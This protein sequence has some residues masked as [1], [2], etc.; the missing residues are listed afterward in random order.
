MAIGVVCG[1]LLLTGAG[2]L[3]VLGFSGTSLN[4]VAW[5]GGPGREP[6]P[7]QT[8]SAHASTS[9]P[10][11]PQPPLAQPTTAARPPRTSTARPDTPHPSRMRASATPTQRPP[12]VRMVRPSPPAIPSETP[13]GAVAETPQLVPGRPPTGARRPRGCFVSKAGKTSG[14]VRDPLAQEGGDGMVPGSGPAERK[15]VRSKVH[16]GR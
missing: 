14:Q 10:K 2:F 12:A 16:P 4:A 5:L 15:C 3:V 8:E 9:A 7:A 6:V 1:V 11:P 13:S